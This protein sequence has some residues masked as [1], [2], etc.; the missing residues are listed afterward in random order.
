MNPP[1]L[2]M[3]IFNISTT[4]LDSPSCTGHATGVHVSNMLLPCRDTGLVSQS[5]EAVK[6]LAN[7]YTH[8]G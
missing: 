3:R 1:R 7:A 8:L 4:A 5:A 2:H 6:V